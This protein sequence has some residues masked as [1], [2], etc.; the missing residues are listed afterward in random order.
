MRL[1]IGAEAISRMERGQVELTVSKLL[2][3]ADI[4][5]C[6]ANELLLAISTRPQDQWQLIAA[7][8]KDLS[9]DDRQFALE[10]LE[11]LTAHLAMK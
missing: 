11:R 2:Q 9:A 4:F 1:E 8:L 6:P 5:D 3:L 7:R 10:S